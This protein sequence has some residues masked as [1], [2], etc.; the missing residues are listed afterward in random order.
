MNRIS[1]HDG[2]KVQLTK[3]K[4]FK[5]FKHAKGYQQKLYEGILSRLSGTSAPIAIRFFS[6][7]STF[8]VAENAQQALTKAGQE[9]NFH[10]HVTQYSSLGINQHY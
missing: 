6:Y 7:Q 5:W 10:E 9:A 2:F 3:G 8:L 4:N 1:S